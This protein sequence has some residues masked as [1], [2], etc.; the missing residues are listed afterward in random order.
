MSI[1]VTVK[2]S[3]N[4]QLHTIILIFK[5][6]CRFIAIAYKRKFK[7]NCQIIKLDVLIDSIAYPESKDDKTSVAISASVLIHNVQ[8]RGA[9]HKSMVKP[10]P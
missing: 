4:E 6:N 2:I 10:S 5:S 1:G 7:K 8:A 3:S 9:Q